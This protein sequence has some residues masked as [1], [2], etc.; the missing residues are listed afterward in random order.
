MGVQKA[1][2]NPVKDNVLQSD[3]DRM[4]SLFRK[5]PYY[6]NDFMKEVQKG[7]PNGLHNST[8][9]SFGGTSKY[10]GRDYDKFGILP[11]DTSMHT[12]D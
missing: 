7:Y 6:D 2:A 3:I 9:V 4:S 8:P 5:P 1:I 12:M 10:K 11:L